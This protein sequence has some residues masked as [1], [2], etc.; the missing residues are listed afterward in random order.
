MSQTFAPRRAAGPVLA[1]LAISALLGLAADARADDAEALFDQG[2]ALMDDPAKLGEACRTLEASYKLVERGDTLL[3]LAECHRREG[4]TATAYAEFDK[5]LHIGAAVGFGEAM[6]VAKRL[7]DELGAKLS[8][9]TVTVPP[10][11]LS[12]EGLS[13][14]LGGKP[15]AKDR[16]NKAFEIDPGPAEITAVA[17]GYRR[18]TLRVE[19]GPDKDEK[20][21]TVALDRE[22]PA[23]RPPPPAPTPTPRAA[24]PSWPWVVGAAGLGLAG[25]G[26]AF[27]FVQ[28]GAGKELD[29]TCG[30]DRQACPAGYDFGAVRGRELRSFGLFVGLG[31]GGLVAVG[32]AGIGLGLSPRASGPK[33]SLSVS[34]T[35]ISLQSTF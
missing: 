18:F 8:R 33:A 23:P 7:R 19:V 30:A 17:K 24:R 13:V 15:L 16:W 34:P 2:R 26:V 25:A 11:V 31:A 14:E 20:T 1:A 32:A 5:A 4:K 9:L 21:A 22:P 29:D 3:N 35:S 10:E 28:R 6:Q 27:A 12:L